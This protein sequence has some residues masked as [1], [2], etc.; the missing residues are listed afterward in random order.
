MLSS[1]L[2]GVLS[3]KMRS[4]DSIT[5]DKSVTSQLLTFSLSLSLSL[6]LSHSALGL[7]VQVQP[8]TVSVLDPAPYNTFSIVCTAAVPTSVTAAKQFVWR[9]GSTN[10]TS[11]AGVSITTLDLS[12]GTSTSVLTTNASAPGSF[13]YTCEVTVS[14][15]Q[16]SAT[17]TVTVNGR[18]LL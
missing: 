14:S 15:S 1:M 9:V 7:V 10:L 3:D 16:S 6:S 12:N 13:P 2:S 4:L 17:A 8:T 18:C 11:G 5:A